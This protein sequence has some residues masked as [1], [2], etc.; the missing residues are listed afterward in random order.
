MQCLWCCLLLTSVSAVLLSVHFSK[1][2][3]ETEEVLKTTV[4]T[5]TP[6]P[7]LNTTVSSSTPSPGA[8]SA[9]P[10]ARC[11]AAHKQEIE[12]VSSAH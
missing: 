9:V 12:Q 5:S 1:G 3:E 6:S 2:S 8:S 7:G 11:S 10:A 4:S